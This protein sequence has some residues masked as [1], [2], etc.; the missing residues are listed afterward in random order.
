M[1]FKGKNLDN[2]EIVAVKEM[3]L[4]VSA[5]PEDLKQFEIEAAFL[6]RLSHDN[7][8]KFVGFYWKKDEKALIIMEYAGIVSL[9]KLHFRTNVIP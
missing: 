1:V 2:N 6:S 7:I 9:Y 8:I 4:G 5:E 3:H